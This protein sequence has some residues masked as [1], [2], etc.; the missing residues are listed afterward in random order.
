MILRLRPLEQGILVRVTVMCDQDNRALASLLKRLDDSLA[1]QAKGCRQKLDRAPLRSTRRTDLGPHQAREHAASLCIVLL[2]HGAERR[3]CREPT[4]APQASIA[5]PARQLKTELLHVGTDRCL[6][7]CFRNAGRV[8]LC[9]ASTIRNGAP[10]RRVAACR[11]VHDANLWDDEYTGLRACRSHSRGL[12]W[13]I[14][15]VRLRC[16]CDLNRRAASLVLIRVRTGNARARCRSA[17]NLFCC[18]VRPEG[19]ARESICVYRNTRA[20]DARHTKACVPAACLTTL[21]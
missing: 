20:C 19:Q 8:V 3:L 12:V 16:Q 10:A 13:M 1:V 7:H 21:Q 9:A 6:G 11:A 14:A 18:A 15:A 17:L 2:G 5:P 4:R